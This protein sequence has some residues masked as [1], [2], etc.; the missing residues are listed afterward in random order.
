[1]CLEVKEFYKIDHLSSQKYY[2]EKEGQRVCVWGYRNS[3]VRSK[4]SN[5]L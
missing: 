4:L 1:M 2:K 3:T 5:G